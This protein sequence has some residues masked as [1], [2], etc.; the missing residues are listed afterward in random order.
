MIVTP[1][2]SA[3][4]DSKSQ[5]VFYHQMVDFTIKELIV[6]MQ[7]QQLCDDKELGFF[8]QYC[9]LL[10]YSIEAMRVK[11]M[12]DDD[13]NIITN[14]HTTKHTTWNGVRATSPPRRPQVVVK[15]NPGK[16]NYFLM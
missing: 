1:L 12:Y 7:Q 6:K 14:N 10:L 3:Q 16:E 4:L 8:K 2:D 13:A 5:Y 15:Q 9:D 11:Y